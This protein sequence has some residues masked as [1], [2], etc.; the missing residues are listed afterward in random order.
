[1]NAISPQIQY[2]AKPCA[3]CNERYRINDLSRNQ[4]AEVK[5]IEEAMDLLKVN[6]KAI[7]VSES[8]TLCSICV[9]VID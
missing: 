5:S 3:T 1:M 6:R 7:Y 4:V 2:V 9:G 8:H